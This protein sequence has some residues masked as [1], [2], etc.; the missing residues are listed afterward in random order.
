MRILETER[1]QLRQFCAGDLEAY[2]A[3]LADAE[4]V[5]YIGSGETLSRTQAWKNMAM[6][7]GHWSL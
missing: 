7:L 2:A 1:L 5:A 6:V 4:V 3:M